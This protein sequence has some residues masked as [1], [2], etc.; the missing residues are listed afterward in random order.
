MSVKL[1]SQYLYLDK[2][3]TQEQNKRVLSPSGGRNCTC[4]RYSDGSL[5]CYF[6]GERY[7]GTWYR[8][9]FLSPICFCNCHH[10][11]S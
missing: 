2:T 4:Y 9:D 1:A 8:A 11:G 7:G 3:Q 5:R 10:H 6:A